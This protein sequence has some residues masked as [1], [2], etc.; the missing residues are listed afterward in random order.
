[1]GSIAS[2]VR[3]GA[4]AAVSREAEDVFVPLRYVENGGS[5]S[6]LQKQKPIVPFRLKFQ[7]DGDGVMGFHVTVRDEIFVPDRGQGHPF[8]PTQNM[9]NS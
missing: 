9:L 2:P 4:R 5:F 1:M 6:R 7:V 8:S 3:Q